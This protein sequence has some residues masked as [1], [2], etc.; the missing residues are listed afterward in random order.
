MRAERDKLRGEITQ[1]KTTLALDVQARRLAEAEIDWL[2]SLIR[3]WA[4]R[5]KGS[6]PVWRNEPENKALFDVIKEPD[7]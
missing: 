5:N 3:A 4:L 7:A 2:R 1:L 6:H